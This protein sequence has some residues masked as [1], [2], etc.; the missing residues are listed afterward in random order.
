MAP[1]LAVPPA[2]SYINKMPHMRPMDEWWYTCRK[3]NCFFALPFTIIKK[4]SSQSRN[5]ER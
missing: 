1:Y 4:V 2:L 5:F 3:D